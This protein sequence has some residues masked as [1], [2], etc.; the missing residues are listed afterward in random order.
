[1]SQDEEFARLKARR[2]EILKEL[3]PA[4]PPDEEKKASDPRLPVPMPT[5]RVPSSPPKLPRRRKCQW[6][7]VLEEARWM[8]TDFSK[9]AE[10]KRLQAKVLAT[11][12]AEELAR[13]RSRAQEGGGGAAAAAETAAARRTARGAAALVATLL[14][15]TAAKGAYADEAPE[16]ARLLALPPLPPPPAP[17]PP[18]GG[19]GLPAAQLKAERA[20]VAG[21]AP[22][23]PAGLPAALLA[24]A[25][26][27][28]GIVLHSAPGKTAR[29]CGAAAAAARA[30]RGPV[31]L[32]VPPHRVALYRSLLPGDTVTLGRVGGGV[33]PPPEAAL[34]G[35]ATVVLCEHA[36]LRSAHYGARLHG[37]Q[38]G[39]VVA[40]LRGQV[41]SYGGVNGV[42]PKSAAES[43]TASWWGVLL[44]LSYA[45]GN[46]VRRLLVDDGP[47]C[48]SPP[49]AAADFAER[50]LLWCVPGYGS[51]ERARELGDDAPADL[52]RVCGPL[53]PLA[54]APGERIVAVA[55]AP[56][57]GQRAAYEALVGEYANARDGN[58]DITTPAALAA[59]AR[60]LLDARKVVFS[61]FFGLHAARA[62]ALAAA[63]QL[64]SSDT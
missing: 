15:A 27:S 48:P 19:R 6:D 54:A 55:M 14:A 29:A 37:D 35:P 61:D 40:D 2:E 30:G 4:P 43:R 62:A 44:S 7:Y 39:L 17:P 11:A 16:N 63:E 18:S 24:D 53:A 22:K 26:G 32:V 8:A 46:T 45:R 21:L 31:L 59:L 36:V 12:V 9:E 1:M 38:W 42:V 50:R 5:P 33:P 64:A 28:F 3:S 57:G 56:G 25:G 10:W 47:A 34:S 20:R 49:A 60:A 51:V 41:K 52:A 23:D 58:E 13:R